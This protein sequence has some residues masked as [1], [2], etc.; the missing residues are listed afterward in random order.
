MIVIEEQHNQK[1]KRDGNENP[2]DGQVPEIN[3]PKTWLRRIKG[4]CDGEF[5]YVGAL[6]CSWDV[7]ETDPEY[8][9]NL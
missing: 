9:A 2:S 7:S 6:E 8:C 1:A 4:T 5:G 3:Q